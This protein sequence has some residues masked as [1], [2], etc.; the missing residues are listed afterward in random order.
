VR[1]NDNFNDEVKTHWDGSHLTFPGMSTLWRDRLFPH[2]PDAVYRLITQGRLLGAHEV[3]TGKTAIIVVGAME[4]RRLK[5]AKKPMIVAL[6]ANVNQVVDTAHELYPAARILAAH[7]SMDANRR[8]ETVTRIATGDWDMV[9]LT[10][11]NLGLIP[12][13]KARQVAFIEEELQILRDQVKEAEHEGEEP[14][15]ETNYYSRKK[16]SKNEDNRVVKA[17]EAK[18]ATRKAKLEELFAKPKDDAMTFEELGVDMLMVDEAHA[19]RTSISIRPARAPKA[20]RRVTRS[21][22]LIC[23]WSAGIWPI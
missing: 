23:L 9:I 15:P 21:G 20:Y 7:E 22:P 13:S 19:L 17:L 3:G 8:K 2:V 4:S 6:N 16:K 12:M 1:Y 11:D 10:H 14:E 5:L 18:I